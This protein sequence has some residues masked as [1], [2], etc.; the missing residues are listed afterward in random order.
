MVLAKL[1]NLL[2]LASHCL[3]EY[4]KIQVKAQLNAD[5]TIASLYEQGTGYH[6]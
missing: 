2:L 6:M 4:I 5:Q 3:F 1:I